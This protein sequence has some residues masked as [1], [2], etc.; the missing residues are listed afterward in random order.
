MSTTITVDELTR[1]KLEKLK[2]RKGARSFNELLREMAD[3]ELELTSSLFGTTKG[4]RR[5][6]ERDH[7]E[8]L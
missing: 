1:I 5:N 7:E 6:F 8:R 2:Y 3:R 4:L